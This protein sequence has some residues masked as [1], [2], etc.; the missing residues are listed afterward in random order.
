MDT[1]DEKRTKARKLEWR[2]PPGIPALSF[3]FEGEN[4]LGFYVRSKGRGDPA[5]WVCADSSMKVYCTS[6]SRDSL[7]S[8]VSL[9]V[10]RGEWVDGGDEAEQIGFRNHVKVLFSSGV[11]ARADE[12]AERAGYTL[13]DKTWTV[14]DNFGQM[15]TATSSAELFAVWSGDETL[16]WFRAFSKALAEAALHHGEGAC[17]VSIWRVP[18]DLSDP[19]SAILQ[20]AGDVSPDEIPGA[21]LQVELHK[22]KLPE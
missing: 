13:T 14:T 19:V 17:E 18:V 5:T 21:E 10:F 4:P 20:V 2:S 16:Q 1:T 12:A 9:R 6:A 15:W 11:V 3:L 22:R 8:D 7:L